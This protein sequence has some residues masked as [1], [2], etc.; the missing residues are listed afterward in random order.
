M[1]SGYPGEMPASL[2]SSGAAGTR[3]VSIPEFRGEPISKCGIT[4]AAIG[5][6]PITHRGDVAGPSGAGNILGAAAC[7]DIVG[8]VG[9]TGAMTGAGIAPDATDD[10]VAIANVAPLLNGGP[11]LAHNANPGVASEAAVA[12]SLPENATVSRLTSDVCLGRNQIEI[13]VT[14]FVC[15]CPLSIAIWLSKRARTA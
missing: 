2:E 3:P 13:S 10:V 14:P 12:A 11:A 4:G 5:A 15:L 8:K 1:T 9:T 6:N 7:D